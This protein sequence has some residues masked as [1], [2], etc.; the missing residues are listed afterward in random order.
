MLRIGSNRKERERHTSSTQCI[1]ISI[2]IIVIIN[3]DNFP[4][5]ISR[6]ILFYKVRVEL[7][8]NIYENFVFGMVNQN[9]LFRVHIVILAFPEKTGKIPR[10][11]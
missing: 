9:L 5:N 7:L 2:R 3:N 8:N 1:C 6:R 11:H 10:N 4:E